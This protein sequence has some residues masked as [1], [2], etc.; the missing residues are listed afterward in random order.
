MVNGHII[1]AGDVM[2]ATQSTRQQLRRQYRG[3]ELAEAQAKLYDEG[4][5]RLI[6][7]RLILEAF[8][9]MGGQLPEGAVRERTESILRE[10]FDNNRRELLNTL[11][12]VGKT[13]RE[14]ENE[15]RD[16]I[17]VQ[18]MTATYVTR[19]INITPRM[20]RDA[21][22]ARKEEFVSPVEMHLRALSLRPV[23]EDALPERLAFLEN[24]HAELAAGRDFAETVR[25]VSQG[26]QAADGGDQGWV[27][28]S[29][30]PQPIREALLPLTPGAISDPVITPTQHFI[31]LVKDRRGGEIQPIGAVQARLERELREKEYDR[32]YQEWMYSLNK[33]YPV[34]RFTA[35]Q[36]AI[37]RN[38]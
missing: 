4:L 23:A 3:R 21:Y 14:W 8:H 5:E 7:N 35:S 11:R 37:Q 6:E 24:L 9:T 16:Q 18:Q 27:R 26:P 36:Q 12:R 28:I 17:I 2:E 10:R 30:L 22:E 13:E 25:E 38:Q 32:I 1:T 20:L 33:Q 19:R 31:F 34:I 15:L 29:S